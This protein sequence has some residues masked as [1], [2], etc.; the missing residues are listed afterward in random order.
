MIVVGPRARTLLCVGAAATVALTGHPASGV[1]AVPDGAS[2]TARAAAAD[3]RHLDCDSLSCWRGS[4]PQK[5]TIRTSAPRT[6]PL[7]AGQTIKVTVG[8]GLSGRLTYPSQPDQQSLVL[9]R[10]TGLKGV[11]G[12][13]SKGAAGLSVQ[14]SVGEG[15]TAVLSLRMPKRLAARAVVVAARPNGSDLHRVPMFGRQVSVPVVRPMSVIVLPR[16]AGSAWVQARSTAHM[17]GEPSFKIEHVLAGVLSSTAPGPAATR[18]RSQSII[19]SQSWQERA[20]DGA[21]DLGSI[22]GVHPVVAGEVRQGPGA[23]RGHRGP[24]LARTNSSHRGRV[25]D[26]FGG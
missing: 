26:G 9:R 13:P 8:N 17:P 15:D 4:K 3:R 12:L 11:Q 14:A 20:A 1:A 6:R 21:A 10:V 23:V 25:R 24:G 22:P 5:A 18:T 16:A 19:T 2:T 7:A